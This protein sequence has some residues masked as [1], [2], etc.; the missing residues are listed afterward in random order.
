MLHCRAKLSVINMF[1]CLHCCA[2]LL[3]DLRMEVSHS[4]TKNRIS[5][6]PGTSPE[7]R[8]KSDVQ[9]SKLGTDMTEDECSATSLKR[10]GCCLHRPVLNPKL[11]IFTSSQLPILSCHCELINLTSNR[12][13]LASYKTFYL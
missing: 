2:G 10:T 8:S 12:P 9:L 5:T 7:R 11:S 1:G 13:E 4:C 6:K 3:E